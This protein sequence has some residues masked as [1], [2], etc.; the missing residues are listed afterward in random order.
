V[1]GTPKKRI[2]RTEHGQELAVVFRL[3]VEK[4]LRPGTGMALGTRA[5]MLGDLCLA[6]GTN[7]PSRWQAQ[8]CR[9]HRLHRG[10]EHSA[11]QKTV[12]TDQFSY[13][14]HRSMISRHGC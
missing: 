8:L 10:I 7:T 9:S 4:I 2:N 14:D 13:F 6:N 11:P 1:D 3:A 5:K 12:A